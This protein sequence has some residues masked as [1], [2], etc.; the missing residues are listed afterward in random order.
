MSWFGK[1]F[2]CDKNRKNRILEE[3]ER[4]TRYRDIEHSEEYKTYLDYEIGRAHV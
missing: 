2:G 1:L 3:K 4:I